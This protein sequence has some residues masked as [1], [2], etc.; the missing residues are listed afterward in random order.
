MRACHDLHRRGL[1]RTFRKALQV[2]SKPAVLYLHVYQP[3]YEE[4]SFWQGGESQIE[5]IVKYYG[6]PSISAR[7]ALY[8]LEMAG[9]DGFADKQ[10]HCGVHPNPLG[11]T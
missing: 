11:H 8:H 1:E 3:D 9:A 7:D 5:T 10:L 2:P 6:I 4:H